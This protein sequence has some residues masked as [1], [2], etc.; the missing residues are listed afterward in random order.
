MNEGDPV[1]F[2]DGVREHA[3][4]GGGE[5]FECGFGLGGLVEWEGGDGEES[6]KTLQGEKRTW[7]VW[8]SRKSHTLLD[9]KGILSPGILSRDGGLVFAVS[10]VDRKSF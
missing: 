3:S 10:K 4:M 7:F 9:W 8:T 1:V 6:L 2:A 5:L